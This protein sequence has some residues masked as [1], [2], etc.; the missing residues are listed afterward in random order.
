MEKIRN[1]TLSVIAFATLITLLFLDTSIAQR[2]DQ[3]GPPPFGSGGG[4]PGG[5][6]FGPGFEQENLVEKFDADKDGKLND[7]E[8]KNAREYVKNQVGD[9]RR[10]MQRGETLSETPQEKTIVEIEK[11]FS[12]DTKADLYDEKVLRT[13]YLQFPNDDWFDELTDFYRTG[14]E[15][16]AELIVDGVAYP[17]VGIRFRGNTSYMM[18]S[19]KKSFNIS[20]DCEDDNQRLYGYRT[21]NLLNSNEDPSLIREVLYSR[22]CRDYMPAPKANFVKL[23]VNGEYW[24]LYANIQQFNKDFIRDWFGTKDGVRWKVPA[25]FSGNGALVWNGN[26]PANYT[27]NYEIKTTDAPNAWNDLIKLCEVLDKT[28]DDQL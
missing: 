20:I 16:P 15:V 27:R 25:N 13:L 8:R 26:D 24:G 2:P 7:G 22:I 14:V 17:S 12:Y 11:T 28:P 23:V 10:Q 9:R 21:L 19:E 4:R 1:G 3:F 18:A 6:G 5:R